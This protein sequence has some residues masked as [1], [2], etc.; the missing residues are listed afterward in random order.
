M[1]KK[2][3]TIDF[4]LIEIDVQHYKKQGYIKLY[5]CGECHALVIEALK[6]EHAEWHNR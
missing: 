6:A 5:S 1:A 2:K 4:A 3:S